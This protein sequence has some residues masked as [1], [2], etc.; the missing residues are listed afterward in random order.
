MLLVF[1]IALT[2]KSRCKF[3]VCTYVTYRTS[4]R[5]GTVA[6]RTYEDIGAEKLAWKRSRREFDNV[7]RHTYIYGSSHGPGSG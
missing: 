5:T 4:T 6:L 7:I 3:Y 2:R 1:C